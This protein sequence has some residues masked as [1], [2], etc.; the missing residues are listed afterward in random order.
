MSVANLLTRA[1]ALL[2][3]EGGRGLNAD[4][5]KAW[6]TTRTLNDLLELFR[7]Q[8]AL[9]VELRQDN[10][11]AH[12]E[13][14][15]A[16]EEAARQAFDA[17]RRYDEPHDP[18]ACP[19]LRRAA[20]ATRAKLEANGVPPTV[21]DLNLRVMALAQALKDSYRTQGEP[22]EL[23][24]LRADVAKAKVATWPLTQKLKD[25]RERLRT[26]GVTLAEKDVV[27]AHAE[28][29]AAERAHTEAARPLWLQWGIR[30]K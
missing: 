9:A 4:E 26:V 21:E 30:E 8:C 29:Q 25:A 22:A 13:C 27:A 12:V 24:K 5:F 3:G 6:L 14:R 1:R 10:D 16:I 23:V 2:A 19:I 11:A 20:E 17:G 18:E 28:L 15:R 7:R